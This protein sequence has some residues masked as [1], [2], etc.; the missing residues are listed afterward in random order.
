MSLGDRHG[1]PKRRPGRGR[2]G[3]PRAAQDNPEA[4]PASTRST[5]IGIIASRMRQYRRNESD[6][7][8]VFLT[9]SWQPAIAQ[10]QRRFHACF[11]AEVR[12][13]SY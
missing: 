11:S 6:T 13:S 3:P 9:Q 1:D 4:R 2:D 5:L 8:V 7:T 10:E 12:E